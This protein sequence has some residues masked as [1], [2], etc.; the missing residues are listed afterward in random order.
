LIEQW[1]AGLQAGS[2]AE[3]LR[4]GRWSYAAVNGLHIVGIAM[5]F[6]ASFALALRM[7]GIGKAVGLVPLA[8]HLAPVA[9]AGAL[10][11]IATGF[12][13]FAVRA[14]EYASLPVFQLKMLCV[15]AGLT[16]AVTAHVKSGSFPSLKPYPTLALH[17]IASIAFWG[18]AITF[19][20]AIAFVAN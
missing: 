7:L 3:Y 5:L 6:G 15:L 12:L 9:A 4:H 19:G 17:G 10:L 14:T 13:L 11:A 16:S 20:R 1:L 8:R 18:M 2:L